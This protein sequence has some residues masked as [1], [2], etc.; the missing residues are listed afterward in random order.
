MADRTIAVVS[1][2]SADNKGPVRAATSG[3]TV[4][5][6]SGTALSHAYEC[7]VLGVLSDLTLPATDLGSTLVTSA[8]T[9]ALFQAS[10]AVAETAG[11]T[12]V[13]L[14][15][16]GT[17]IGGATLSWTSADAA[18]TRKTVALSQAVVVGD[19]LSL[20]VTAAG[21]TADG[22]YAKVN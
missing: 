15:L 6:G 20:R 5:D 1:D 18:Y 7:E 9:V 19:R 22:I 14:E 17:P 16:N 21:T 3:D 11:T 4:V 8:G 12:T 13:V 10:R 2:L